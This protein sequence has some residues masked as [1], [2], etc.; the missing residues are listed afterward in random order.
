MPKADS[1][2]TTP[3]VSSLN[4]LSV[5]QLI[6]ELGQVKAEAAEIEQREKALKA[7]LI[8]RKVTEAEGALFRATVTEALRQSLDAEAIKAEMGERWYG[9]HCKVG[10]TTTVRVSARISITRAAA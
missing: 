7:E 8:A 1:H 2:S 5:G 3:A 9:I 10:V 6:D 4:N